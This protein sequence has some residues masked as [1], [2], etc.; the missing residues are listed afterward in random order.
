MLSAGVVVSFDVGEEF[1]TGGGV[2]DED[3]SIERFDLV[4][5]CD[6]PQSQR[7]FFP[8][9][10]KEQFTKNPVP[11]SSTLLEFPTS[12]ASPPR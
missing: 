9:C 2:V 7:L 4:V 3:A 10:P 12:C 5:K 1:V 8:P 11:L 6:P